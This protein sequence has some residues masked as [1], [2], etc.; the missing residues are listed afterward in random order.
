MLE[1]FATD[2]A[3][4]QVAIVFMRRIRVIEPELV[5][6][7]WTEQ[8]ADTRKILER[9]IHDDFVVMHNEGL[10]RQMQVDYRWQNR[11]SEMMPMQA[12]TPGCR[13][14]NVHQSFDEGI[15]APQRYVIAEGILVADANRRQAAFAGSMRQY[16]F[17]VADQQ[18]VAAEIERIDVAPELHKIVLARSFQQIDLAVLTDEGETLPPFEILD[19]T[20]A[21][22]A[23][24]AAQQPSDIDIR[25]GFEFFV[26]RARATDVSI[27]CA[28][29][30]EKDFH[31]L[32]HAEADRSSER[33]AHDDV[34]REVHAKDHARS[35]HCAGPQEQRTQQGADEYTQ[36]R[37]KQEGC[38]GVT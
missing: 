21:P 32:H 5:I 20:T 14:E 23:F 31:G 9:Q 37:D 34:G 7:P 15:G 17:V 18:I 11:V 4:V 13:R 36:Q 29:D 10:H 33:R 12:D 8:L 1:A 16:R 30:T 24:A 22:L 2:G 38:R 3:Q 27:T 25:E 35:P 6:L 26:Y 28:L 19:R